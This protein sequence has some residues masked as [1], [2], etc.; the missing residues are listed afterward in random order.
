MV[1]FHERR[2]RI[3]LAIDTFSTSSPSRVS[4]AGIKLNVWQHVAA[5]WDGS[6]SGSNIHIY[7][8]GVLADGT[9]V[10]G[11]G[12]AESDA[13]TPF[14]IGNRSVDVARAFDGG[15][16]EVRVY[17]GVLTAAEIQ[18][19]ANGTTP[20]PPPPPDTQAP[21]VPTG[22]KATAVTTSSIDARLDS[23]H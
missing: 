11:A 20:P 4:T 5:T 10:N 7:I 1:L 12:M 18:A 16:D 3:K 23:I 9:A 22:L 6:T 13:D 21:T 14:A 19:L 15:I 17:S 8:N 2:D